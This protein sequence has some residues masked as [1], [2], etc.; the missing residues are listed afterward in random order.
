MKRLREEKETAAE[1]ARL[2]KERELA[3]EE[4]KIKES[5]RLAD[6]NKAKEEVAKEEV[7]GLVAGLRAS[8]VSERRIASALKEEITI[9]RPTYTQM[10]RQH[11]SIETL[12][13]YRID[14]ELDQVYSSLDSPFMSMYYSY[15]FTNIL[16]TGP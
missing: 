8:G 4:F 1:T 13:H 11:L 9:E 15:T 16:P 6:E 14:Y 12:R 7:L 2:W 5:K 3:I 10:A